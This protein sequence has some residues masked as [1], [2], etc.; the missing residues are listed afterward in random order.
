M[1]LQA[2]KYC[3]VISCDALEL[4][5]SFTAAIIKRCWKKNINAIDHIRVLSNYSL[6]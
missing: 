5:L 3:A 2:S 6:Q 1:R 4:E